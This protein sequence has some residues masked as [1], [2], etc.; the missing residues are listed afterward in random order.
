MSKYV[1][2]THKTYGKYVDIRDFKTKNNSYDDAVKAALVAANKE[3][4]ALYING[5]IRITQAI[6]INADTKDVRGIFGDGMGKTKILFTHTQT[7]VHNPDSNSTVPEK[8]GIWI[9][10][11]NGKFIS[12]LSIQY[13]HTKPT[14]FYRSGQ[15]YFGKI[16]GIVVNDSDHTLIKKVEVSG[17]N[18]AGV[19]FTSTDAVSTG[20][21]YSLINGKISAN[22]LP[23]GDNNKIVDSYLHHNRVAGILV[24]YQKGFVA[25]GNTLSWNGHKDDGGTG[26]G[27]ALVAGSY[28]NGIT[29]AKNKTDHNYR[30]GIDSHDGNN[31]TI[32]DNILNG[33][34][35]Y[36]IAV[37]NRQFTMDKVTIHNNKI[38]QDPSFRLL[39]DDNFGVPHE[40]SDYAGFRGIKLENKAQAW[41]KF[42]NP[43]TGAFVITNNTIEGLTDKN[44]ITRGIEMRNNE[45]DATYSLSISNNTIKGNSSDSLISVFGNP[46]NPDT[47]S[48][49]RGPGSGTI[50]IINNTMEV[51]RSHS[52]PILIQEQN[53]NGRLHGRIMIESN[54]LHIKQSNAATE[55]LSAETNAQSITVNQ[56][57][58]NLGGLIDRPVIRTK[59]VGGSQKIQLNVSGNKFETDGTAAFENGDWLKTENTTNRIH[60]NQHNKAV[61]ILGNNGITVQDIAAAQK[62]KALAVKAKAS[63][64]AKM[65]SAGMVPEEMQ[66]DN[67]HAENM[68]SAGKAK[69][70]DIGHT[71]FSASASENIQVNPAALRT[72]GQKTPANAEH[73]DKADGL[74]DNRQP[75]NLGAIGINDRAEPWP[76]SAPEVYTAAN[77][78]AY[79]LPEDN[80]VGHV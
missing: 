56:N 53:T 57:T 67:H 40:S 33:D 18:R 36:G 74:L 16:N 50:R 27:I 78:A 55:A 71:T 12:D 63:A 48:V 10:K 19:L 7:G 76:E 21:K 72:A 77:S 80:T 6:E 9:N 38:I 43:K 46:D 23:T 75:L 60:S 70:A 28:N 25:E 51:T 45:K 1:V 2:R 69:L 22:Q 35:M 31:I 68:P 59:G 54:K 65:P 34:R 30:K 11:Q 5:M 49:E 79:V 29:I 32:K 24:S 52:A 14:D 37:E 47:K 39:R 44:G 64:Q 66:N 8:A 15:S 62:L 42:A 73:A 20:A 17:A 3:K 4:A 41:Q 26:Y 58:F 13:Q 61:G